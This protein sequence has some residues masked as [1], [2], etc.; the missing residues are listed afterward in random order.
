MVRDHYVPQV[1]VRRAQRVAGKEPCPFKAHVLN[2]GLH[3]LQPH[4][5]GEGDRDKPDETRDEEV[6]NTNVFVVGGHE[7]PGEKAPVIFVFMAVDGGVCHVALP[8][9]ATKV[10]IR[11]NPGAAFSCLLGP[12]PRARNI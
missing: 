11:R 1:T 6:Q 8:N 2:T 4:E 12:E 3:K 9:L 10:G 7:P 5:D